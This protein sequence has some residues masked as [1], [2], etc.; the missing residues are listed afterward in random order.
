MINTALSQHSPKRT[1]DLRSQEIP[2]E[3]STGFSFYVY[4]VEQLQRLVD[5]LPDGTTPKHKGKIIPFVRI[6]LETGNVP[7]TLDIK[8]CICPQCKRLFLSA[9]PSHRKC[10]HIHKHP[11]E[12][13]Y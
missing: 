12:K 10:H 8:Q 11:I 5:E 1:V 9:G 13:L 7:V 3:I 4:T 6:Q 2:L